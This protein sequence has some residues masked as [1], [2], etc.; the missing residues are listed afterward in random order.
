LLNDLSLT[1]KITA[2]RARLR[3]NAQDYGGRWTSRGAVGS[4]VLCRK[5]VGD[6]QTVALGSH[7]KAKRIGDAAQRRRPRSCS[8]HCENGDMPKAIAMQRQSV[9]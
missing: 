1:R 4:A 8:G 2:E 7:Q 3:R 6:M 5:V 9:L